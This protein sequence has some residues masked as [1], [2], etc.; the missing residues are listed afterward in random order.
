MV[1]LDTSNFK[2]S[3]PELAAGLLQ[4]SSIGTSSN[5]NTANKLS[6]TQTTV[7]VGGLNTP[8]VNTALG[9]PTPVVSSAS[10]VNNMQSI[11]NTNQET[12]T[13][14]ANQKATNQA[15]VLAN[16]YSMQPGE[17]VAAYNA[18]IDAY[19]AQ[20]NSGSTQQTDTTPTPEQTIA[21]TPD[22]GNQWVYDKATGARTQQPI[23]APLLPSQT[24][25]DVNS[26]PAADTVENGA[27]TI[28]KFADGTY[29]TFDKTTGKYVGGASAMDFANAKGA[30]KAQD[31][32]VAIQNGTYPLT[33]GQQAQIDSMTNY[34]N[35]LIET[36]KSENANV[37]GNM[38]GLQNLFGIGGSSVGLSAINKTIADGRS[39]ID[40]LNKQMTDSVTALRAGLQQDNVNLVLKIHDVYLNAV[41]A[42]QKAIDNMHNEVVNAAN[43]MEQK[44][45]DLNVAMYKKFSDTTDP[46]LPSDT[47][48][49]L[50][51]K[52]ATSP[53]YA[54]TMEVKKSLSD[55][56][57]S[58][59]SDML[60]SGF[61]MKKILPNLGY[62]T[63][64]TNAK[65]AVLKPMIDKAVQ[66]GLS[67]AEFGSAM[68]DKTSKAAAF[69]K[70]E[71]KKDLIASNEA[72][73]VNDFDNVLLPAAKSLSTS[74]WQ[75]MSPLLNQ[76]LQTGILQTTGDAKLNNYLGSLTTTL[77]K[78][79]NVVAGNIGSAGATQQMNTEIQG[80][81]RR[82]LSYDAIKSY[83]DTVAKPEMRNTVGGFDTIQQNIK[84]GLNHL[85][86]TFASGGGS[87]TSNSGS[88]N[89]NS[90]SILDKYGIK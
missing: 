20:K 14:I 57:N 63:A 21:N 78:Y 35:G 19:N 71:T 41:D 46:I 26:S 24:K 34:Y 64:G 90:Q 13:N 80:V 23:N 1:S 54:Q 69:S 42:K 5:V 36:Q 72:G 27:S 15:A 70:L 83:V 11:S 58:Y 37:T 77:T 29:G 16:P 82:G 17:T 59:F 73:V 68:M 33:S 89:T 56:E 62:G 51:A 60:T 47:A 9:T 86:G 52:L 4:G 3:N 84:D 74:Q 49:E 32:L 12:S 48:D 38:T 39:S 53:T 8:S 28:K 18:R 65:I 7:T 66:A 88:L 25:T 81:L 85:D 30:Q 87:N 76:W 10:A 45:A 50:K 40:K 44:Q 75:T 43:K 67:G 79:S 22:T 2:F 31:D 61:D 6:P 55:S